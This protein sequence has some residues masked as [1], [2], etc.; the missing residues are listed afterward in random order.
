MCIYLHTY[1]RT[2]LNT[3]V[4]MYL[5]MCVYVHGMVDGIDRQSFLC[6]YV[7]RYSMCGVPVV[8]ACGWVGA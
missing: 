8:C 3:Y 7:C 2:Y 1:V 5:R 4:R 6:T